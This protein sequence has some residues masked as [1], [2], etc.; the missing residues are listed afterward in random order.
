MKP[1][2]SSVSVASSGIQES[3]TFGIKESGMAHIMGVRRNQLYSDKVLAV[4][5]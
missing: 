4:V 2:K 5:R 3:V 1:Q